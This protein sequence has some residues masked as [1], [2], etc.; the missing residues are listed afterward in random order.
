MC[1]A[2][3]NLVCVLQCRVLCCNVLQCVAVCCSVW[4]GVAPRT[5]RVNAASVYISMYVLCCRVL[6]CVAMCCSVLQCV[7]ECSCVSRFG[8]L[9]DVCNVLQCVVV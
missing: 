5:I 6:Q 3:V 8:V 4:Q 7:A 1:I 9:N 2:Q